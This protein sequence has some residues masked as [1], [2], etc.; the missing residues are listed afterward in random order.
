MLTAMTT[1]HSDID[2][3]VTYHAPTPAARALHELLRTSVAG[4]AH[5][6]VDTVPDCP[7]RD[8]ALRVLTDVVLA[9]LNAAVARNHDQL[10]DAEG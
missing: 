6:V 2:H 3:R 7:E 5:D 8:E 1:T 10:H 9:Q 4:L